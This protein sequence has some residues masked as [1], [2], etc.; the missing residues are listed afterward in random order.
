MKMEHTAVQ[1]ANPRVRFAAGER[2]YVDSLERGME[3]RDLL[4]VVD[5]Y[6]ALFGSEEEVSRSDG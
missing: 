6:A 4:S 5:K 2:S 3:S 1:S